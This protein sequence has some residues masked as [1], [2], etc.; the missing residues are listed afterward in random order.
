MPIDFDKRLCF[1]HI[2]KTGGTTI[3]LNLEIMNKQKNYW[4]IR[5]NEVMQHYKWNRYK[6]ILKDDYN[7]FFKFC[8]VR[9]PYEKM[10]S[11]YYWCNI[12]GIGYK[13]NQSFDD[14]IEYTRD[15]VTN[16]KYSLTIYHDHFIP[17][18][19]FLYDDNEIKVDRVFK[20]E[21]IDKLFEYLVDNGYLTSVN[22]IKANRTIKKCVN[23]DN[24]TQK[25]KDTIYGIYE[26][27]FILFNYIK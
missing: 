23:I 16:K 27:D 15:I 20:L 3:E 2:P 8:L 21:R 6:D 4:G 13:S 14:F 9:N 22:K 1:I 17:Q 5:K 19:E 7:T 26:K 11:E 10:I 18:H 25:Q 24:L 12:E